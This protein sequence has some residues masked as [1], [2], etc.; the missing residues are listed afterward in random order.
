MAREDAETARRERVAA[1][2]SAF[3]DVN[4]TLREGLRRLPAED[5]E[6]VGLTCE[7]GSEHCDAFIKVPMDVYEAVRADDMRFIVAPGHELPD[8]EDVVEETSGYTIVR[9]HEDVRD[10]VSRDDG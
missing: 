9:K 2:E 1:N 10:I 4:E 5:L 7:C 8:A 6:H 3:R